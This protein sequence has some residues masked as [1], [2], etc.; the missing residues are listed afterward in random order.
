MVGGAMIGLAIRTTLTPVSMM[1]SAVRGGLI[2]RSV[3]LQCTSDDVPSMDHKS[4]AL[5]VFPPD[6]WSQ[7]RFL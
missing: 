4:P 1:K 7:P 5:M 2:S 6:L 3:Q